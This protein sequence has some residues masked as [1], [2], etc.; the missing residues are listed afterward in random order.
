MCSPMLS[1]Q[2][3]P[4]SALTEQDTCCDICSP[5]HEKGESEFHPVHLNWV[6][7][8]DTTGHS[9]PQMRWVADR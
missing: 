5:V 3:V 9:R 4:P 8:D 7:V 1:V 6:L 2:A